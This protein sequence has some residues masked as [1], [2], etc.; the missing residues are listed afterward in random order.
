[1]SEF[2]LSAV[3]MAAA[4]PRHRRRVRRH[5]RRPHPHT[6]PAAVGAPAH[7]TL[8][9]IPIGGC[10]EVG[11]NMT[12]LE[13]GD[14]I[15]I[16][17]MGVMFPEEDQPGID[18]I[19]PNIGYLK[20]KEK[21]IRGIVI[22]HAH[23]DHI[24][25]ISYLAPRLG[26]PPIF[27][28]KLSLAL[29]K[30]RHEEFQSSPLRLN[31][32][33]PGD[34]LQ[35]GAFRVETF[36]ESHNIPDSIGLIVHTPLGIVV[37][38]GDFKFDLA[39]VGTTPGDI[40]KIA[41]LAD[42]HV[43]ALL[44][45]STAAERPGHQISESD[46]TKTLDTIVKDAS[47]RIIVG[48]FSTL[49][50]R[51]QQLFWIAE[52]H[53]RKVAIEGFSMKTNVE[54]ARELGYMHF[55]KGLI[56]ETR[57]L[58]RLPPAQQMILCTG[59]MGQERAALMR[60]ANREHRL[61][62]IEPKDTIIFSSSVIPGN[63]RSVQR[64]KDNL[65]R[66]GAEVIHYQMMDV[67]SGGH[68][69]QDDLKLMIK[70]VNPR[71]FIPIH[72]NYSFL[73]AHGKLALQVG[74]PRDNILI[75]ENGRVIEFTAAGGRLTNE[76]VPAEH[77]MVDGLGV[78]DVS[79][80]VLRDRKQLADDGMLVV[81]VTIEGKTGKLVTSPDIISR[82]FVYLKES[83]ELIE[84]IRR[85]VTTIVEQSGGSQAK[86]GPNDVYLRGKI[87]DEIG[88]FLFQKTERRPMVLPVVI[89]V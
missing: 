54:I 15:L 29:I 25:A 30:K 37:N 23:F 33:A 48:L 67:H 35:L 57:D 47:G 74:I 40:A 51:I 6:Q 76:R 12:I 38:T 20:G 34:V 14:D 27:G 22:T 17:D 1:M 3:P 45:D 32:V 62:E 84:A 71:Y 10:D 16:M 89:E 26:N 8:R 86:S 28:T 70:L 36:Y 77:V 41:A 18:F 56:V 24:G 81:I 53:N 85:M 61:V 55:P 19:I 69:L 50:A 78:G 49:L 42:K 13:Y 75:P 43:L 63:E 64:L 88:Q 58:L 21:R 73:V 5:G 7:G 39:P 31:T 9:L 72:G 2:A 52:K 80:I 82:G 79:E 60:I 65:A 68:G 83:K 4:P 44:S 66:Q 11:K 59:A 87:R 46:I